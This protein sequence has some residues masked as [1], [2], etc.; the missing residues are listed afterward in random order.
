MNTTTPIG[1][2]MTE[3]IARAHLETP[4]EMAATPTDIEVEVDRRL[5]DNLDVDGKPLTLDRPRLDDSDPETDIVGELTGRARIGGDFPASDHPGIREQVTGEARTLSQRLELA[6]EDLRGG[7][8]DPL[9]EIEAIADEL[10][11]SEPDPEPVGEDGI[12]FVNAYKFQHAK[13]LRFEVS[14]G[15]DDDE[16]TLEAFELWVRQALQEQRADESHPFTYNN[17]TV[18]GGYYIIDGKVCLPQDYDPRTKGRKPGTYPPQWAGGP[19]P[20]TKPEPTYEEPEEQAVE[21]TPG[22]KEEIVTALA[23]NLVQKSKSPR[24]GSRK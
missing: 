23:Q 8:G 17:I 12:S 15:K 4:E 16:T 6:L 5:A 3:G 13:V 21:D 9:A 10:R 1:G 22:T 2:D 19:K 20:G 18:Q 11:E 14:V 7:K 24:R